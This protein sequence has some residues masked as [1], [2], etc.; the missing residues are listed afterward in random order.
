MKNFLIDDIICNDKI[1]KAYVKDQRSKEEYSNLEN[2]YMYNDIQSNYKLNRIQFIFFENLKQIFNTYNSFLE[3][4][5]NEKMSCFKE[6]N[7]KKEEI[8]TKVF[9][10]S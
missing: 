4:L 6:L 8:K 10:F 9:I 7:K 5:E 1:K 2:S 3:K